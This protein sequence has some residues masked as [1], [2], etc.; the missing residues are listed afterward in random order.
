MTRTADRT[1]IEGDWY[2]TAALP[3]FSKIDAEHFGPALEQ[4]LGEHLSEIEHIAH[5]SAAPTFANTIEAIELSGRR[6]GRIGAVFGNLTSAHTNETLQALEREFAPKFAAHRTAISSNAALFERVQR[7][8]EQAG[9]DGEKLDLNA[10]QF[11]LLTR[12]HKDFVRSGAA[13]SADGKA[14]LGEITK[15]LAELGT[16]FSQNVLGDEAEFELSLNSDDD[17]AGL[18]D[19][20]KAAMASAAADRDSAAS[21][22]VTLSRSLIAPFL[23]FSDRRDLRERAFKAWASRGEQGGERDNREIIRETLALRSERAK[24]LG[25]DSFADFKLDNCMAK[26]P[27]N[28]AELLSTVWAPAKAR[29]GDECAALVAMARQHGGSDDIQP[30][31]WR[32]WSEKVRVKNYDLDEAEVKQYFTLDN[33]IAAAFDVANKLFN[34]SFHERHDL[35][36]YHP[37]VRCWQVP[38]RD[39]QDVGLFY[40]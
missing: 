38:D 40:R 6:L 36:L 3:E 21:H 23:T 2:L 13:L 14:R 35:D 18:P 30:W 25:F 9:A 32:Y 37:D 17:L 11:Q 27:D 8:W 28:V 15:R 16:S 24:L 10:E 1:Y 33:M 22:V 34:V 20:L 12:T 26:T 19:F 5:N 7:V 4:A 31:D 29:V 39:G